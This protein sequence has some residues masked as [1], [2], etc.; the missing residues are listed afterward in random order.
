MALS[1]ASRDR[2][3]GEC[4][5]NTSTSHFVRCCRTSPSEREHL[6]ACAYGGGE[7]L[8]KTNPR[9]YN[10]AGVEQGTHLSDI[11]TLV[12]KDEVESPWSPLGAASSIGVPSRIPD[13]VITF[14]S[15]IPNETANNIPI[16]SRH[17]RPPTQQRCVSA[18]IRASSRS[19]GSY[20][21]DTSAV[22]DLSEQL[23]SC[24]ISATAI[25]QNSAEGLAAQ[26]TEPRVYRT[27]INTRHESSK[28][29]GIKTVPRCPPSS[30]N[31]RAGTRYSSRQSEKKP[32]KPHRKRR[33]TSDKD[34][35]NS[36]ASERERG[37]KPRPCKGSA[38]DTGDKELFACPCFKNNPRKYHLLNAQYRSCVPGFERI[39]RLK[40]HL[41]RAHPSLQCVTC[42][43]TFQRTEE[44]THHL[45]PQTCVGNQEI[46]IDV[47]TREQMRNIRDV[48]AA[49]WEQIFAIIYPGQN[50]PSPYYNVQDYLRALGLPEDFISTVP[51]YTT[52]QL[53]G[54]LQEEPTMQ[55]LSQNITSSSVQYPGE[56]LP[57][58][59]P[60]HE[61]LLTTY[62]V[63]SVPPSRYQNPQPHQNFLGSPQSSSLNYSELTQS[64]VTQDYTYYSGSPTRDDQLYQE[65][66]QLPIDLGQ[67][68]RS[69][70]SPQA[71]P[72]LGLNNLAPG[73]PDQ[74][75]DD[76]W[77]TSYNPDSYSI[78]E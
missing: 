72:I 48:Y 56:T 5:Y 52:A 66:A 51:P 11:L 8:E 13:L 47:I 37:K 29:F 38:D 34:S 57:Q 40:Q 2:G 21:S 54:M 49:G 23:E 36:S 60:N 19:A 63:S 26:P 35:G 53:L 24:G 30:T 7:A 27:G 41:R 28:S 76:F 3:P 22:Q 64:P 70:Q 59:L 69:D 14:A 33:R 58:T 75:I 4:F 77:D 25:E 46:P 10:A 50:V 78:S 31:S 61:N 71:A 73:L 44:L 65:A 39:S 32:L 42:R 20:V 15:R 74:N 62:M 45:N 1:A 55:P 17:L 9:S 12:K 18:P 43:F 16:R 6:V 67:N 68:L